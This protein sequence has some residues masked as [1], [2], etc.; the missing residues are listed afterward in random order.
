MNTG[1]GPCIK[2]PS[3]FLLTT[4]TGWTSWGAE[5]GDRCGTFCLTVSIIFCFIPQKIGKGRPL[6]LLPV[7]DGNLAA[8]QYTGVFDG[9]RR[10]GGTAQHAGDLFYPV[11]VI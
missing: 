11:F 8:E 9:L 5:N 6:K 7:R 10:E 1:A 3:G 4:E 2:H